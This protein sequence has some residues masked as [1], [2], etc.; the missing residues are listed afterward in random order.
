MIRL[1]LAFALTILVGCGGGRQSGPADPGPSLFVTEKA[2]FLS[3][4]S[5]NK[6]AYTMVPENSVV[7]LVLN[8]VNSDGSGMNT[9]SSN[10]FQG[11][12]FFSSFSWSPT[13]SRIAYLLED[14]GSGI[15]LATSL[16]DGAGSVII[17]NNV[18][19][20]GSG[21]LGVFSGVAW[22]PDGLRLS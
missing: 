1:R 21:L 18:E 11:D 10:L 17:S 7:P 4:P 2:V 22:S 9:I 3:S 8:S 14:T 12:M 16:P 6:I 20:G 5:G 19:S 15:E 13:G